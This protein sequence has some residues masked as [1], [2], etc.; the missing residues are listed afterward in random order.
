MQG[1]VESPGKLAGVFNAHCLERYF[2]IFDS[3]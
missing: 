2:R 3:S 1:L